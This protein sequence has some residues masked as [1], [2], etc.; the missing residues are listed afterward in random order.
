MI[1]IFST[2]RPTDG[3]NIWWACLLSV[4]AADQ[5]HRRNM[6]RGTLLLTRAENGPKFFGPARPGP[7]RPGPS[8]SGP[9]PFALRLR[10]ARPVV[11]RPGPFR[12]GKFREL[13]LKC[14]R[15]VF[16]FFI[17]YRNICFSEYF[18]CIIYVF[19]VMSMFRET[20]RKFSSL[21]RG[22]GNTRHRP[23]HTT[24]PTG[25]EPGRAGPG[26]AGPGR[27]GPGRPGLNS[28]ARP[29]PGPA[30]QENWNF[31]ARPG[32]RAARPVLSS[33]TYNIQLLVDC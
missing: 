18:Y 7:A 1:C 28:G 27:A 29:G 32:P 25:N 21:D 3:T 2:S 23:R 31:Q 16:F 12:L 8:S 5:D 9:G 10:S 19:I 11:L 20:F 6:S 17:S 22:K 15:I 33:I 14:L 30:R 13:S 24:R 26:R 4:E